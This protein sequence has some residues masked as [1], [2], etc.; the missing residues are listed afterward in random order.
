VSRR[1]IQHGIAGCIIALGVA[2]TYAIVKL[3]VFSQRIDWSIMVVNVI[4]FGAISAVLMYLL[5]K[6][7]DLKEE[8]LFRD[9]D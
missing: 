6:D 1:R 7:K 3:Y 2:V 9:Y 5:K 4:V 8:D